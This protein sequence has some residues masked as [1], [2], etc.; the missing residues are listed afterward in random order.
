[1]CSIDS[2]CDS[3]VQADECTLCVCV[4]YIGMGRRGVRRERRRMMH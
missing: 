4:A 3:E 2:E 1:M